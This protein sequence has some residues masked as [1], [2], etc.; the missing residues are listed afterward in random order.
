MLI[1]SDTRNLFNRWVIYF[2]ISLALF[3]SNY[4]GWSDTIRQPVEQITVP[5]KEFIW[6]QSTKITNQFRWLAFWYQGDQELQKLRRS[7]QEQAALIAKIGE[8]ENENANLRKLMG[9]DLPG[10]WKF[11]PAKVIGRDNYEIYINQGEKHGIQT[12]MMAILPPIGESNLGILIGKV[13]QTLPG[14]SQITTVMAPNTRVPVMI[15]DKQTYQQ[16]AEGL[17]FQENNQLSIKKLL[18][19]EKIQTGD[20]VITKGEAGLPRQG[21]TEAGWLPDIPIGIISEVIFELENDLYQ[22][23]NITWLAAGE[24]LDRVF[25]VTSW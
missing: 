7:Y 12:G 18:P 10:N 4:L 3:G 15:R 1:K 17:L 13:S 5:V 20:L 25:V 16:V 23:A 9:A 6:Q 2:A 22:Q 8:L 24:T 11:A 21:G 14:Q 19:D